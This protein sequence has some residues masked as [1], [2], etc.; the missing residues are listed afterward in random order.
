MTRVISF[1]LPMP[2]S[3]WNLYVGRGISQR[4]SKQY[5]DWIEEAGWMLIA[6]RNRGGKFK[7]F[8]GDVIVTIDAYRGGNKGR[9]IDN[10][11]KAVC[12]LL[13]ST[14]T[15]SNDNC[16]VDLHARWVDEGVPCTVT[17]R[18]AA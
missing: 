5:K 16:V 18:D 15:I 4:R 8:P 12:D 13:Q 17:V 14:S 10:I 3:L 9:D 6:Q 7:R 11:L 1:D 2:P